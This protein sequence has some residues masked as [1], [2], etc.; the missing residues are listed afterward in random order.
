M[1]R[2]RGSEQRRLYLPS[3]SLVICGVP[4]QRAIFSVAGTKGRGKTGTESVNEGSDPGKESKQTPAGRGRTL[5]R[6]GIRSPPRA[7]RTQEPR[8][9]QEPHGRQRAV[10]SAAEFASGPPRPRLARHFDP[11]CSTQSPRT[12]RS[13][14]GQ[15][16]VW[17]SPGPPQ[18][19]SPSSAAPR[20]P[21]LRPAPR[22]RRSAPSA[23]PGPAVAAAECHGAI[24]LLPFLCTISERRSTSSP[25][26]AGA[27]A[28]SPEA[29]EGGKTREGKKAGG[30]E[31]RRGGGPD[32]VWEG[33][34]A[35]QRQPPPPPRAR[36]NFL[37]NPE[38][39][40][41][42]VPR[43]Q[44]RTPRG[45]THW[46]VGGRLPQAA[47]SSPRGSKL[48]GAASPQPFSRGTRGSGRGGSCGGCS[49]SCC[50]CSTTCPFPCARRPACQASPSPPPKLPT[51][52]GPR[53]AAP[54]ASAASSIQYPPLLFSPPTNCRWS[55][56][57]QPP[58]PPPHWPPW[59]PV[60]AAPLPA[61][62]AVPAPRSPLARFT[63]TIHQIT[64]C[65][66]DSLLHELLLAAH[67]AE[68]FRIGARY[69]P[70]SLDVALKL[71]GLVRKTAGRTSATYDWL[72]PK[73]NVTGESG[74]E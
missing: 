19:R 15:G 40:Q 61:A 45:R 26:G 60:R 2:A 71:H 38:Q 25:E 3:F 74:I 46:G 55:A 28:F 33:R 31:K 5:T 32:R 44:P 11:E 36:L 72:P 13:G 73:T 41:P 9:W 14:E 30:A 70:S 54:A 47:R 16:A 66:A 20:I 48:S 39:Y 42:P 6:E 10:G 23:R 12:G 52:P 21:R 69:L 65:W 67:D 58:S 34:G 8:G 43:V 63:A 57:C 56:R 37:Y 64:S 17:A 7:A 24:A 59:A 50:R 4:G 29:R 51:A 1:S 49:R 27:V 35:A 62:A 22:L 53:A 18:A 68:E